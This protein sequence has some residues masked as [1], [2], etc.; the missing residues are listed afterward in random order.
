M[1]LQI[2]VEP[3]QL[4]GG[5]VMAGIPDD[6]MRPDMMAIGDSLYQGVRSLT[7]KRGMTQLSA[8]ALVA[9]ALGIRHR[10]SCPDPNLPILIDMER[11]LSLLPDLDDVKQDLAQNADYWFAM[12]KSPSGRIL[13]ENVSVA[14]ATVADLYTHSWATA[15]AYLKSLPRNAKRRIKALNFDGLNLGAIVQALNTRF[16]LNPSRVAAFKN[17]TQVDQVKARRP[18]RLLI[19]IGSNNGL[20]DVAFESNPRGRVK[21]KREL[22]QLA[23]RLNALP[24]D[25]EAIYF[26]NLGLPSTVPN[27]MPLPDHIEWTLKPGPGKY[28]KSY[29]NRFGFGYGTMTGRQLETLDKHVT[30]VN[31]DA[32]KILR[33]AFDNRSRLH[34]VDLAGLLKKYDS[35]HRKRTAGNVV[36]LRNGKTLTNVTTEADFW[37][38]FARGGIAGLDGMHLTVVGYGMMAQRVLDTIARAER[39]IGR[40]RVD[41]DEAYRRDKLLNYMPGV[42]SVG[43]WLWRDIR[44]AID[45]EDNDQAT[46]TVMKACASA[47]PHGRTTA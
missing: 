13:F 12:P 45:D 7:I 10:F 35:K 28:F 2:D 37:G 3:E 14:S 29:E 43:L 4:N 22:R 16:T 5:R 32:Q 38:A 39:G 41:L 26:N 31:K 27:L 46:A 8:P 15:D 30:Q 47:A 1:V 18:K 17:M 24:A 19:N 21:L 9:E 42:W 40:P 33:D 25:V 36:K 11:W 20:W 44:R 23:R 6:Y 34:F